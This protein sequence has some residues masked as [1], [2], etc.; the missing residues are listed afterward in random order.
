MNVRIS[1][2]AVRFRL[3][4]SELEQV[5][6]GDMVRADVILGEQ[7]KLGFGLYISET[8]VLPL[9]HREGDF[10]KIPVLRD[11]LEKLNKLKPTKEG[12]TLPIQ[13]KTSEPLLMT[14]EVDVRNR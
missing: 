14:I 2:Q 6:L 10:Y 12:I 1:N 4:Q 13:G 11:L 9:F 5:L 7:G 3:S 8:K